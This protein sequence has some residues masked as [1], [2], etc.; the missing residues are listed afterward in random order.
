MME[1]IVLAAT[2]W[3]MGFFPLFEIYLA[4]PVSMGLGL[5]MV[6]SIVWAWFGNFFAIPFI[7][8]SYDWLTKF[9]RIQRY[10]HKLTHSKTSQR[11]NKGGF[12]IVLIGTPLFGSWAIG[13]VG[14]VIGMD[15]KRLFLSSAISIGIYGILI[16]VLTKLGIDLFS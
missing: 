2:A 4:I 8:Y 5:D 10:F 16:G 11:L 15:K 13:V 12:M 14:K 7:A 9:E 1:Y 3:F 6:S